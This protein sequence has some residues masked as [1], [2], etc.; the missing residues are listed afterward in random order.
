MPGT[1][2]FQ[3]FNGKGYNHCGICTA[4]ILRQISILNSKSNIEDVKYILPE[5]ILSYKRIL[6]YEKNNGDSHNQKEIKKYS[7][8]RYIEKNSLIQYY[9]LYKRYIDNGKIYKYLNLSPKYFIN[10]ADYIKKY[11]RMLKKFALEIE[12]YIKKMK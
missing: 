10:D 6:N 7:S 8:Y 3:N 11:N 12:F 2:A 1:K 5:E 9:N 4:C